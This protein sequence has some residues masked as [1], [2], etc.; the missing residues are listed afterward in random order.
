[1]DSEAR[2]LIDEAY[3]MAEQVLT[4][5]KEGLTALAELLLEREVIFTEDVERILGKR[6]KDMAKESEQPVEV[7]APESASIE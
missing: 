5:H 3:R 4:E 2:A 7:I 1:I 6:K